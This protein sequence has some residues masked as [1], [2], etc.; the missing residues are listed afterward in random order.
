MKELVILIRPE[1]LED[2]D[3]EP[4]IEKVREIKDTLITN[5]RQ[6]P[7]ITQG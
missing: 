3:V 7:N 5:I 4:V 1:K 2:K 6:K